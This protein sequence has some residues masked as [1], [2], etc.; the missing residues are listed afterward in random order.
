M[1]GNIACYLGSL[2]RMGLRNSVC[3]S[4]YVYRLYAWGDA[5]ACLSSFLFYL[6]LWPPYL[7]RKIEHLQKY[8]SNVFVNK[9][10]T[11]WP[12][13]KRLYYVIGMCNCPASWTWT[14][15]DEVGQQF[16]KDHGAN[17][18]VAQL[19]RN[20]RAG[21]ISVM[22]AFLTILATIVLEFRMFSH[23]TFILSKML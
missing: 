3:F 17:Y 23:K 13:F 5:E 2:G 18:Q 12:L 6:R 9:L 14:A 8:I 19:Q 7:E 10:H 20:R 15:A 16:A 22:H 21:R 4:T 11:H 1:A